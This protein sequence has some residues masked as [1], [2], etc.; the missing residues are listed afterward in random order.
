VILVIVPSSIDRPAGD[1]PGGS[2]VSANPKEVVELYTKQKLTMD[3]IADAVGL[4]KSR[5]HQILKEQGVETKQGFRPRPGAQPKREK[6]YRAYQMTTA[7]MDLIERLAELLSVSR[8][9]V[10]T[11][12]VEELADKNLPGWR[13]GGGKAEP[14]ERARR[15]TGRRREGG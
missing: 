7:T 6:A 5:V 4:S 1:H 9:A 10:V 8:T 3:K 13:R 2:P 12:A 15:R 11:L 14:G